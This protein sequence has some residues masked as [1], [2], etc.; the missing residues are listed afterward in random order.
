M[1]K[2]FAAL[3]VA[4]AFIGCS[5]S[6][7]QYQRAQKS[8]VLLESNHGYGTGFVVQRLNP[9]HES[10]LFIWTANHVVVDQTSIKVHWVIRHNGRKVGGR[11][12]TASVI[13]H[14]NIFDLALLSID[15]P[16]F[17]FEP[18]RFYDGE[19]LPVGTPVF[20][21]GNF[22]GPRLD[23][24]V[25]TGIISQTGVNMGPGFLW[26]IADQTTATV[27]HGSS[28]GP[29]F[30]EQYHTVIGVVVG[31]TDNTIG[32]YVPVRGI[33]AFAEVHHVKWA[34]DGSRCPSD[35]AVA[36]LVPKP[37]EEPSDAD[38]IKA[39]LTPED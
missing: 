13:A 37:V 21:V 2:F 39:A 6:E 15:A 20:H 8:T 31:M 16:P 12:F 5:D 10:R 11:D 3:L 4:F 18:V 14:D 9:Q 27:Q 25:S 33:R 1:R 30:S 34:V 35:D 7:N 32:F 26:I 17:Y 19:L 28:G 22:F 36:N 38:R 29:L 24:S 23:N